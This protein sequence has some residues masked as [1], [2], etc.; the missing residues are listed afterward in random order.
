M[1]CPSP[2]GP[3]YRVHST[4]HKHSTLSKILRFSLSKTIFRDNTLCVHFYR[5]LFINWNFPVERDFSDF[6]FDSA[7][8]TI[9]SVET[10]FP[11]AEIFFPF[12]LAFPTF[13]VHF[14]KWEKSMWKENMKSVYLY[15]S[16]D[17]LLVL[18]EQ[19]SILHFTLLCK[20]MGDF[21]WFFRRHFS[22]VSHHFFL[23]LFPLYI[24][25]I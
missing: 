5:A 9:H 8:P 2:V 18:D 16:T 1:S 19:H 6:D 3:M 12:F 7:F 25:K 13:P 20:F 21:I 14:A 11:C 4:K 15:Q 10:R 24:E 23:L 22:A 17:G